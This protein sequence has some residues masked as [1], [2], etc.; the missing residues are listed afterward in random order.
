MN[1]LKNWNE[2]RAESER[3]GLEAFYKALSSPILHPSKFKTM[4]KETTTPE[5]LSGSKEGLAFEFWGKKT[6][7]QKDALA[8]EYYDLDDK[9]IDDDQVVYIY[10]CEMKKCSKEVLQDKHTQE[11]K[12]EERPT[13][14][15]G[16]GWFTINPGLIQIPFWSSNKEEHRNNKYPWY[17]DAT[18]EAA[19]QK[20]ET[21]V[22]ACNNYQSLVDALKQII[23]L[24]KEPGMSQPYI[25]N[26]LNIAQTAL[27]NSK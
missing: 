27:N 19:K 13:I 15:G 20:A 14:S 12:L 24:K 4:K 10:E 23:D 9:E 3:K 25:D 22:K 2:R 16:M 7:K 26:I 18:V 17:D 5:A 1:T 21:I 8:N 6:K 11:F